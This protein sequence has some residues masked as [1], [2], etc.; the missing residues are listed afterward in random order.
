MN[1]RC[2]R[3]LQQAPPPIASESK[4]KHK[5]TS[6]NDE[7]GVCSSRRGLF[8]DDSDPFLSNTNSNTL[9]ICPLILKFKTNFDGYW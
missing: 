5:N 4:G 1:L 6:D 3:H 8:D 2:F 7:M 9:Q